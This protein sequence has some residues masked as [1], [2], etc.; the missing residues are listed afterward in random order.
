LADLGTINKY[1]GASRRGL[2]Q[3]YAHVHNGV[4]KILVHGG[5]GGMAVTE[6]INKLLDPVLTLYALSR[7]LKTVCKHENIL[8]LYFKNIK[9]YAKII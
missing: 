2:Q 1:I 5:G 9:S 3:L 4:A 8:I 7:L 6:A